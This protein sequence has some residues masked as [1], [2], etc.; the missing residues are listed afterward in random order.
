MGFNGTLLTV[1][2]YAISGGYYIKYSSY[3]VTKNI[4]DLDSYRDADGVLHRNALSHAP[5]KVEFETRENLTNSDMATFFSNLGCN[6]V[7]RKATVSAYVPEIDSYV[8]QDMY[9]SDPQFKIKKIKNG[10]IYYESVRVA[11][12]GY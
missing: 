12:I 4:Q 1:N 7:E 3:N 9:M 10:V 6:N 2:G 11:F 8:T 5:I